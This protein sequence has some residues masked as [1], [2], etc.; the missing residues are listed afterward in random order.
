MKMKNLPRKMIWSLVIAIG[1]YIGL[2]FFHELGIEFL[3]RIVFQPFS[4]II[5]A[6]YAF[7]F[8]INS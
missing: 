5:M 6:L 2:F 1:L 4:F 7:G 3:P 8:L